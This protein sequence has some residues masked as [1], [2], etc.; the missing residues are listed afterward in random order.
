M[1]VETW[2]R[3]AIPDTQDSDVPGAINRLGTNEVE[4]IKFIDLTPLKAPANWKWPESKDH[5]K[6]GIGEEAD[7]VCVGDIN[8][9]ISQEKRGGGAIAFQ[10]QG[11]WE[12]LRKTDS[13][14]KP[15]AA[16]K[17]A[18]RP[19]RLP[20]TTTTSTAARPSKPTAVKPASKKPT[21]RKAKSKKPTSKKAKSKKASSK[22]A[23][24][25]KPA[26]KKASSKKA[27]SKK[28]SSKKPASKKASSKK[29][30]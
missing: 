3:G 22:K 16:S 30:R 8:R 19:P 5:A 4:D 20:A 18:T 9:M 1:D 12:A 13:L 28:A 25:K 6:W 17:S 26:S 23:S 14:K 10:E 29:A 21:S 27:S 7:W 11:L 15:D 2:I 24:S